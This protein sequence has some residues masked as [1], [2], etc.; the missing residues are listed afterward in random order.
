MQVSWIKS[1]FSFFRPIN[2]V[3]QIYIF[4]AATLLIL[5]ITFIDNFLQSHFL[6]TLWHYPS[7]ILRDILTIYVTIGFFISPSL[8]Q[9]WEYFSFL[10][11]SRILCK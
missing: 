11:A 4:I 6:T 3:R 2:L 9:I 5:S 7:I 10:V 1:W 8:L